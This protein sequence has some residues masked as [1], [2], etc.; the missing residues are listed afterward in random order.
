M[1]RYVYYL[2][3]LLALAGLS[4]CN[5][6]QQAAPAAT[7]PQSQP[8]V[9][10]PS[11]SP[12]ATTAAAAAISET[13]PPTEAAPAGPSPTPSPTPPATP[14]P[15]VSGQAV[16]PDDFPADYNPLTG[17]PSSN[18]DLLDLPAVLLSITNFP[19][20]ARPQ[21][22]L[23]YSPL[24]FE[25]YISEGMTRFLVPFYADYPSRQ[26]EVRGDCTPLDETPQQP[27]PGQVFL[28]NQVWLDRNENGRQD[29]G[30][31]PVGGV[32]VTLYDAEGNALETVGTTISHGVYAFSVT[33][34]ETY[35][36]G[37]EPP[38]GYTF[39]TPNLFDDQ[40]DSDI[41]PSGRSA[42]I[43]IGEV[44]DLSWDAGLISVY[45]DDEDDDEDDEEDEEDEEEEE[46]GNGEEGTDEGQEEGGGITYVETEGGG[47]QIGPVRSGRLPYVYIRDMFSQSCLVYA[48][49]TYEIRDLLRGCAMVY[50]SDQD[51]INS[52]FVDVTRLQKVAEQNAV[53]GQTFSYGGNRFDPAPPSGGQAATELQVY[54]SYLNQTRWYYDARLGAYL[55][56]EDT[57]SEPISF[58]PATD[59]LTG[60]ALAYQNVVILFAEHEV[61]KPT[62][63]DIHLEGGLRGYAYLFRDGV[64]QKIYWSTL[65]DDYT[66][67]TGK[68]R[69]IHFVDEN[70]NPVA[71]KP[72]LTWV[73]VMTPYS[74]LQ[75][76]EAGAWLA[77][78]IAPAGAAE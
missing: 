78:F 48:S 54:Y 28:G 75:E 72:G 64:V 7:A 58:H 68:P 20:S 10:S 12:T 9:P 34:G 67:T 17:L 35:I 11:P 65:A 4:A 19:P 3:A 22:G 73:H 8:A 18:P 52:A 21:A 76:Q 47:V 30:E 45:V 37:V 50:G 40:L 24:I 31:P 29:F 16:G 74:Y 32:C 46:E 60:R 55:R 27:A 14:A 43:T 59:R 13:A 66:K 61:I 33:P 5:L 71:L 26:P 53:P 36:I 41:L 57:A 1:K 38:Q 56:Y 25:I 6:P 70:G 15:Q 62:I 63:I 51:D 39:T 42:L 44:S 2:V 77:R 23:S 49:A 69:P